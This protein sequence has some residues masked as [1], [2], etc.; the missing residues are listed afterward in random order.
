MERK[1][2]GTHMS[3]QLV[4]FLGYSCEGSFPSGSAVKKSACNTG[5]AGGVGSIPDLGRSSRAGHG[6]SL[7]SSCLENPMDR[8]AWWATVHGV[9]KS[10]THLSD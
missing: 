3:S 4:S 1:E 10:L 7:Q 6:N 5:D 8:K 2:L 9:A